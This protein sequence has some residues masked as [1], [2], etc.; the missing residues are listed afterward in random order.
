M[1]M[2]VLLDKCFDRSE[3]VQDWVMAF[4]GKTMKIFEIFCGGDG[5]RRMGY[6][7][8]N[9]FSLLNNVAVVGILP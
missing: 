4:S 3:S 1:F 6:N 5:R 7:S 9:F 2:N 8:E